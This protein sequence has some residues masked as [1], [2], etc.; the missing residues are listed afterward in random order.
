M[1]GNSNINFNLVRIHVVVAFS[2]VE[3]LFGYGIQT[4]GACGSVVV[5]ALR[6]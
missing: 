2:N 3:S 6:Y 5:K 1:H 4:N